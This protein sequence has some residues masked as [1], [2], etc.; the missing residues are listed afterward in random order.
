MYNVA[1]LRFISITSGR[2]CLAPAS[3]RSFG[4]GKKKKKKSRFL[5]GGAA[6]FSS[7]GRSASS[8]GDKVG[9]R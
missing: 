6:S 8:D 5:S 1:Y 2:Y 3:L 7:R 4:D 9:V